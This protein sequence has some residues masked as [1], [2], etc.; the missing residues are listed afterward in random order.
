M[1]FYEEEIFQNHEKLG[2]TRLF[3]FTWPEPPP[4]LCSWCW[5]SLNPQRMKLF[6]VSLYKIKKIT[7][8]Y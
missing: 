1:R 7:Y 2:K 8:S 5:F 4:F 6:M 3:H